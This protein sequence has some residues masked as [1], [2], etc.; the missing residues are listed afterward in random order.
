MEARLMVDGGEALPARDVASRALAEARPYAADL[1]GDGTLIEIER[2]LAHG[3]G[4]ERQ[5][6]AF[7]AGGIPGVLECLAAATAVD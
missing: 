2:I 6:R 4:A 1:G 5:R 7:E 3:N